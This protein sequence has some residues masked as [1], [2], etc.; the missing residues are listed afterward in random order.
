MTLQSLPSPVESPA[1]VLE[2]LAA[3]APAPPGVQ[4]SLPLE[5]RAMALP[6]LTT[7]LQVPA[8]DL[9]SVMMMPPDPGMIPGG[10]G[11]GKGIGR[12]HL[13]RDA[14]GHAGEYRGREHA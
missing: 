4:A 3:E 7:P 13:G 14:A 10:A 11:G 2:A 9:E 1:A 5:P 8:A 6:T 12:G